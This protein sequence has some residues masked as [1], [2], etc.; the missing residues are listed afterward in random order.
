MNSTWLKNVK[1]CSLGGPIAQW[2]GSLDA[3]AE[4]PGSVPAVYIVANNHL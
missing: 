4:D 2:L 1:K 3:L